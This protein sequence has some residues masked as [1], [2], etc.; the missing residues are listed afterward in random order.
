MTRPQDIQLIYDA[1]PVE[2]KELHWIENTTHRFGDYNYFGV[3]P[4]FPIEWFS[5]ST[6]HTATTQDSTR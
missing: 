1:L 6:N 5:T 2:D 3:H 4:D